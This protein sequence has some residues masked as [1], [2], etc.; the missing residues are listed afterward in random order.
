MQI[1]T[2]K[3]K[4]TSHDALADFIN[5]V[6]GCRL[7]PERTL[8]AIFQ[9]L[10]GVTTNDL[11]LAML[12]AL[13]GQRELLAAN[14]HEIIGLSRQVDGLE[15]ELR[16]LLFEIGQLQDALRQHAH[17]HDDDGDGDHDRRHHG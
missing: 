14:E 17:G 5:D 2:F 15:N 7:S 13:T 16:D 10:N 11:L 3:S 4:N 1:C 12:S 6:V 8:V 9:R